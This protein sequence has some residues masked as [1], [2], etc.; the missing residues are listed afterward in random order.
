MKG[1]E[2][3][4]YL[5]LKHKGEW[6]EVREA[7]F[8]KEKIDKEAAK[9]AVAEC[10]DKYIT[11]IDEEYPTCFKDI[12]KPPIVI[13]YRGDISLINDKNNKIAV[14]GTRK[15]SEYG[16]SMTKN[17]VRELSKDFIIVSGL[18]EGI[19]AIS[20]ECALDNGGKTIAVLGSGIRNCYPYKN[21]EL[22][23]KLEDTQLILSEY[24]YDTPPNKEHFPFRNR[25]IAGLGDALLVTEAYPR[26]GTLI[27]VGYALMFGKDIFC[28]P[29]SAGSNSY[30]NK[31]IKEGAKLTESAKDVFDD[32]KLKKV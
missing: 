9:I 16:A 1:R 14:V 30:C 8:K 12:N 31:L 17:L 3:L 5:S 11:I 23:K 10:E 32:I 7:I 28:V 27:T 2:V 24:P 21:K 25:L 6:E 19:D 20:H 22:Y 26:S 29:Y 4:L 13:F 15:C 18:A